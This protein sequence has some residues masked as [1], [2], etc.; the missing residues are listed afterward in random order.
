MW[1]ENQVESHTR[2]QMGEETLLMNSFICFFYLTLK[3]VLINDFFSGSFNVCV[4]FSFHDLTFT[5]THTQFIRCGFLLLQIEDL[6]QWWSALHTMLHNKSINLIL[7]VYAFSFSLSRFPV[8][9]FYFS[10][11]YFDWIASCFGSAR[12]GFVWKTPFRKFLCDT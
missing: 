12:F 1:S 8:L 4:Y 9:C 3:Y 10:I 6:F 11:F 7:S 2:A 5:H